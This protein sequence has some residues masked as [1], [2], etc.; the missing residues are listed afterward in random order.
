MINCCYFLLLLTIP[1]SVNGW[2]IGLQFVLLLFSYNNHLLKKTIIIKYVYFEILF[3]PINSQLL[4]KFPLR[5]Q[6]LHVF[7]SKPVKLY[8]NTQYIEFGTDEWKS[9]KW[10][11]SAESVKLK[12]N[13]FSQKF[14]SCTD[15]YCRTCTPSR[16]YLSV[17]V[18]KKKKRFSTFILQSR[19]QRLEGILL[20]ISQVSFIWSL[21]APQGKRWCWYLRILLIEL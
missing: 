7:S 15:S 21:T 5:L 17:W 12:P 9:K 14:Q 20:M 16:E 18:L 19:R 13:I 6:Y 10:N 11:F 1:Y 4:K 3:V 2:N 8:W